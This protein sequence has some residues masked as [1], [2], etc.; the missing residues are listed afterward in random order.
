MTRTLDDHEVRPPFHPIS[1][2]HVPHPPPC[3]VSP[4]LGFGFI[5]FDNEESLTLVM[6]NYAAHKI[7]GKWVSP[8]LPLVPSSYSY[9]HNRLNVNPQS[10]RHPKEVTMRLARMRTSHPMTKSNWNHPH[11]TKCVSQWTTA[12]SSKWQG[13]QSSFRIRRDIH[14][15]TLLLELLPL[16]VRTLGLI[17]AFHCFPWWVNIE[18]EIAVA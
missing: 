14:E 6:K 15:M 13:T 4:S 8:S 11:V 9:C 5:T 3:W 10:R 12:T 7:C 2:H 18:I 1:P 16:L 17:Q